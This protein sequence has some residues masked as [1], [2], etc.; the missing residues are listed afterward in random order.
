MQRKRRESKNLPLFAVQLGT[1]ENIVTDGICRRW[2]FPRSL[3]WDVILMEDFYSD[4]VTF[5]L[6][7]RLS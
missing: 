4:A 1:S 2:T 6:G 5:Q 7:P 3:M